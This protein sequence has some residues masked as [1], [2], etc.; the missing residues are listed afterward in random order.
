VLKE[1]VNAITLAPVEEFRRDADLFQECVR[2]PEA[3]RRVQVATA[4]GLQNRD[5]EMALGVMVGDLVDR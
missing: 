4:R 3:Q 5:G 2:K 1:R